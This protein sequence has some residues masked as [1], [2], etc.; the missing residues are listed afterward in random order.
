MKWATKVFT[1]AA[2][3]LPAIAAAAEAIC[4]AHDERWL[5]SY[6]TYSLGIAA[7]RTGDTAAAEVAEGRLSG[8]SV[9]EMKLERKLNIIYRRNS[10]L[11]YA[12]QAF[13]KIAKDFSKQK[14]VM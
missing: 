10:E 4:R 3:V 8:L 6:V 5:L 2:L 1:L 9:K 14:K 13:L 11:S 7:V 12:A